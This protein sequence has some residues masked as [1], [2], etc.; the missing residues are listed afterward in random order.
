MC[1]CMH[2]CGGRG[3]CVCVHVCMCI[4]LCYVSMH[5]AFL[6]SELIMY[7][8]TFSCIDHLLCVPMYC[9]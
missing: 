2:M 8:I 5:G 9:I 1:V 7:H 3:A 4:C 6:C